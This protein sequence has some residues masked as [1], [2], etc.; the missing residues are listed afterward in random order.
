LDLP[1]PKTAQTNLTMIRR[2]LKFRK[3]L[4]NGER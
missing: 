1:K 3:W 4:P 2:K